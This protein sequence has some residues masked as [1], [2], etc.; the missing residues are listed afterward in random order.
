MRAPKLTAMGALAALALALLPEADNLA[1]RLPAVL[2]L[3]RAAEI[4][5]RH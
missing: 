2:V 3:S 5:I 4:I 1:L